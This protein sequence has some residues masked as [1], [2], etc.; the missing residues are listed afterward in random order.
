[1]RVCD[2]MLLKITP[3]PTRKKILQSFRLRMFWTRLSIGYN[4]RRV[5]RY[6]DL[7][8]HVKHL[9][10]SVHQLARSHESRDRSIA[11]PQGV[12]MGRVSQTCDWSGR[13]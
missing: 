6:R 8:L 4:S 11:Q 10:L 7:I 9:G 3:G 13:G 5:R 12:Q 1:M 2:W